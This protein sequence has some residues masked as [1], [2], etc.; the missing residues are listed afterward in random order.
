M[1]YRALRGIALIPHDGLIE[2][3]LEQMDDQDLYWAAWNLIDRLTR[4]R[5]PRVQPRKNEPAEWQRAKA[6]FLKWWAVNKKDF[7]HNRSKVMGM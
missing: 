4:R 7:K 3:L 5:V 6:A 1:R 2:Y